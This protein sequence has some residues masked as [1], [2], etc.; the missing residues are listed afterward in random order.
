MTPHRISLGRLNA[1][2]IEKDGRWIAFDTGRRRMA[3]RFFAGIEAAGCAARSIALIAISHAHYDHVGC[4]AALKRLSG[5]P[6]AV[7]RRDADILRTGGFLLSDGLN[8]IGR[9]KTFMGR[10]VMPR[11]MFA[12]DPVE[13][14]ILVDEQRR[15]DD[16]GF[17]AALIHTPGHSEGSIS[18]LSDDGSLFAGDLTITQPLP[19]SWRHTPIYGS[20]VEEIKKTWRALIDLG[21]RHVYP[22]HGRDFPI[23][24]L[25]ELL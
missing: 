17:P 1:W 22:G 13:P 14:D 16:F 2:L 9:F 3:R 19:G 24:E 4:A 18:L 20:S 6:V 15:L 7:H 10:H 21:A 5:A 25:E 8:W 12:F 11:R 23:S